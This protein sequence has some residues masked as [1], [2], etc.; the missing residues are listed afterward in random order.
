MIGAALLL[1]VA[2]LAAGDEVVARV[3]GV[4]L[5][6]SAVQARAAAARARQL[7]PT[8][9]QIADNLV[10]EALLA[11]E[12]DRLGLRKDPATS[13]LLA[14]E[15]RAALAAAFT[16]AEL[17]FD[18]DPPEAMV[19]DL[20]HATG[21]FAKY[22]LLSYATRADA[23]AA[24]ARVRKGAT[25]QDEAKA[26]LTARVTARDADAPL[27]MRAQVQP[28]EIAGPLFSA[29]AGDVLGPI[30]LR[31]GFALVRV[32]ELQIAPEKDFQAR[33]EGIERHARGQASQQARAH[34]LSR[35]REQAGVK[36]DEAF[37]TGMK[38]VEPTPAEEEH[39]IATLHGEPLRYRDIAHAVRQVARSTG[40]HGMGGAVKVRVASQEIERRLLAR[41]AT[42]RG[43]PSRPEV[44]RRVA[45]AERAVLAGALAERIARETAPPS[46]AEVKAF[47]DRNAKA[48]GRPFEKVQPDAA[49]RAAQ[50]KQS[51]ALRSRIAALR[52]R[53]KVTVD[54]G[55]LQRALGSGR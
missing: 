2:A 20:F 5:T 30:A 49:A 17:H 45:A 6:R 36:L 7:S 38:G 10:E 12:A 55:A 41:E 11:A 19:R 15:R 24:L 51:A 37:L 23:D 31:N 54:Q 9:Q 32:L 27:V 26:A 34:Y 42:A 22:Q 21:D 40:G 33:R 8:P 43:Y 35:L 29:K 13:A 1:A 44:A 28:G 3:D 46:P 53:A 14:S 25:F 39:V 52:A 16:E 50:E 4:D 48:Y 47:Y 18:A